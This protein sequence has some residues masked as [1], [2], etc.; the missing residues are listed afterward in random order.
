[1]TESPSLSLSEIFRRFRRNVAIIIGSRVVFGL[2]NLATN[3]LVVRVFGV[4]EL[5]VA[6]M[7]QGYVR[8]LAG[9]LRL[10]TWQMILRLGALEDAA[11]A[12]GASPEGLR[13][14]YGFGFLLDVVAMGLAVTAAILLAPAAARRLDWPPE[15]AAFAPV[16]VL[17]LPLVTHATAS[18]IL[19]LYDRVD[20]LAWQ[21][22]ANAAIRF[23]G[24]ALAALAGGGLLHVVAAWFAASVLSGLIPYAIAIAEL[25]R[26]NMTPMVRGAW[27]HVRTAHPK[28]WRFLGFTNLRSQMVVVIN[29]G[30][31]LFIGAWFD[32]AATGAYEVAR[33]VTVSLAKPTQ[34]LGPLIFPEL[35]RLAAQRDWSVLRKLLVKQLTASAVILALVSAVTFPILPWLVE[36]LFGDDLSESAWLLRLLMAAVVVNV[37]GFSLEPLL[38]SSDRPGTVLGLHLISTLVYVLV[39]AALLSPLGL[40]AFGVGLLAHYAVHQA[41][42]CTVGFRLLDRR[43]RKDAAKA[44]AALDAGAAP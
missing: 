28:V 8:L 16:F 17:C 44:A 12:E 43:S 23:A 9:V 20:A 40:T 27:R 13:R 42:L 37:F 10:E 18:G 32:A 25:R 21:H 1:M 15:V 11:V 22:S 34:L 3:I 33:R 4:A 6:V 5:G 24:V 2:I 30:T 19:R 36:T 41:M 14:L 38:L 29:Q 35:A 7:L 31:T 39:C 26:R